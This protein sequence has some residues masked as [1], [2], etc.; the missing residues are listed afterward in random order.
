VALETRQSRLDF[1]GPNAVFSF[2]HVDIQI[3]LGLTR[4]FEL[5]QV[6]I[7]YAIL[8]K[9]TLASNRQSAIMKECFIIMFFSLIST[10]EQGQPQWQQSARLG[11]W[12]RPV[13]GRRYPP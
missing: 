10:Q 6:F 1:L 8:L 3:Q 11:I 2:L 9:S 12:S 5:C 13:T 4:V 7:V